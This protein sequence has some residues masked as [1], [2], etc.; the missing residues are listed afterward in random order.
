MTKPLIIVA[1][2]LITLVTGLL[3]LPQSLTGN[4]ETIVC[5]NGTLSGMRTCVFPGYVTIT[6]YVHG[7]ALVSI[8]GGGPTPLANGSVIAHV[9]TYIPVIKHLV[10]SNRSQVIF[11]IFNP[12]G[13]WVNITLPGKCFLTLNVTILGSGYISV[14]A[15][16]NNG[17]ITYTPYTY[18][19]V[20]NTV[21]NNDLDI[22]VKPAIPL[23]CPCINTITVVSING[24]CTETNTAIIE[25]V[26]HINK[27]K[28]N[29]A[30]LIIS[31]VL[32]SLSA[33]ILVI[34]TALSRHA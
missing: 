4:G 22:Y 14:T 24:T 11:D 30:L 29:W 15:I 16:S 17:T 32:I 21:A 26:A 25:A 13:K 31:V 12:T 23:S 3:L 9:I 27:V 19:L 6:N 8:N 20:T 2:A 5:I 7:D 33:I 10:L 34:N 18:S 1:I 28:I